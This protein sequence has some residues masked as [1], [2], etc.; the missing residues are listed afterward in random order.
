MES[1]ISRGEEKET[2]LTQEQ[3][4]QKYEGYAISIS[5]KL[6]NNWNYNL[7]GY[8]DKEDLLQSARMYLW[9]AIIKVD[10][11]VPTKQQST[12]I[13]GHIQG[14]LKAEL[15]KSMRTG[16]WLSQTI[17]RENSKGEHIE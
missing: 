13:Y 14:W 2:I 8:M 1:K 12:F 3:L 7:A 6:W 16:G 10:R 5:N 15:K 9:E 4:Y 17:K 11:T